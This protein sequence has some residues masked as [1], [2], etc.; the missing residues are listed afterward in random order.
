MNKRRNKMKFLFIILL[1]FTCLIQGYTGI[2]KA[3]VKGDLESIKYLYENGVDLTVRDDYAVHLASQ[4]GHLKVVKYLHENGADLT[5]RDN[6]A[7]RWASENG[8]LDIIK[9]LHENGANITDWDNYAIRWASNNGNLDIVKY[10][11]ENSVNLTTDYNS[12]TIYPYSYSSNERLKK[13]VGYVKKQEDKIIGKRYLDYLVED[14]IVLEIKRGDYFSKN[15]FN[16]V[17]E[18]LKITKLTLAILANFTSRG[19][20]YKRILNIN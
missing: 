12:A 6:C 16:Q 8:H 13:V 14:K 18:Y 10:L 7:I 4:S 9:Y 11:H 15:N 5:A 3:C 2:Q 20:K 19:V 1:T 17:L